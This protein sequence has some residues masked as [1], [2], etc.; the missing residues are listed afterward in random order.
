MIDK[1]NDWETEE[2][3]L[4]NSGDQED[5]LYPKHSNLAESSSLKTI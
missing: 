1:H 5:M 2:I 4:G 3:D